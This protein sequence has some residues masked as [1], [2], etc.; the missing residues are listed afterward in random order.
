MAKKPTDVHGGQYYGRTWAGQLVPLGDV[1]VPPDSIICRRV[2]DFPLGVP[3][4][5][6]HIDPCT[7]CGAWVASNPHGPFRDRPRVCMQCEQIQPLP[8]EGGE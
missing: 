2:A 3:P 7:K 4:A 6:A 8:I 1:P 5:G